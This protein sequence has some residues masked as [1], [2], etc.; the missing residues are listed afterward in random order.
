MPD[1]RQRG[2]ARPASMGA[3]Y[4]LGPGGWGGVGSRVRDETPR[5][6]WIDIESSEPNIQQLYSMWG[7]DGPVS[8][9]DPATDEAINQAAVVEAMNQTIAFQ[10]TSSSSA[11]RV[12]QPSP[13]SGIPRSAVVDDSSDFDYGAPPI[14]SG[15][16]ES[17]EGESPSY[18]IQS[19]NFGSISGNVN[20]EDNSE[21]SSTVAHVFGQRAS[22]PTLEKHPLINGTH[23][24]GVE[25]ELENMH[26]SRPRFN[27]WTAKSDGSLRNGGMEFVFSNPWGGRDLYNAA[28]EIDTFLFENNPE[29]TWRCS[30]HVHVDV[31]DM[32]SAQVKKMILAY[33]VYE[34]ILFRCSGWHRYKNNFCVALGFAQEQINTLSN[35]WSLD[36]ASFF[37]QLV[38]N[39][40]KYSAMNLLPMTS[41]GSIE[42]RISEAKWRKGR[43]IRLVNRF[44][45]LKEIAMTFEGT[46]D[47]L[48]EYLLTAPINKVIRKGLPR[49]LPDAQ[50]DIE[51]GFKLAHDIISMGRIRRRNIHHFEPD[52]NDGT[53]VVTT[54]G[55]NAGWSHIRDRLTRRMGGSMTFPDVQPSMYTFKWLAELQDMCEQHGAQFDLEWF[56]SVSL[57]RQHR[58]LYRT[59]RQERHIRPVPVVHDD[60][61]EDD[62]DDDGSSPTPPEFW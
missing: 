35:A 25:I 40:D 23:L 41:F 7:G 1:I 13:L 20:Q 61:E 59:Y 38:T 9:P 45:S 11:Q 46:E 8:A 21:M 49:I 4:Q 2:I 3:R 15:R 22:Y 24:A 39:W 57:S 10:R 60:V 33:T 30:T 55:F 14:Q 42:F 37:N 56:T 47:E 27:Y 62:D 28:I 16:S 54:L 18:E 29:E 12:T 58:E 43:L 53:R 19:D 31:R 6:A 32:T 50:Q 26:M 52:L 48:L 44:L 5:P 17:L 34:R 51:M 36:G